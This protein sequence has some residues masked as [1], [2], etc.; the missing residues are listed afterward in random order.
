MKTRH[1]VKI[2]GFRIELGEIENRLLD[3]PEVREAVVLALDMP[4]GKQLAAYLVCSAAQHDEQAQAALRDDLK[5]QLKSQLPDYMV[6]NHLVLLASMPLTANGK[7]DRRALPTPVVAT[8]D[9]LVPPVLQVTVVVMTAVV[10]S[11]YVPVAIYCLV[12]PTASV[13]A[14]GVTAIELSVGVVVLEPLLPPPPPPQAENNSA[15]S[16]ASKTAR[17]ADNR[18]NRRFMTTPF[19]H[20]DGRQRRLADSQK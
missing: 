9:V 7:L 5:R 4:G 13:L 16:G 11:L 1:Q 19:H 8:K 20:G 10:L 12:E 3:H 14:A 18:E 17:R 2:R 15:I 6:P